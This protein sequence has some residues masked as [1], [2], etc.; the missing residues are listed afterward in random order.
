MVFLLFEGEINTLLGVDIQ[1]ISTF[2]QDSYNLFSIPLS[3]GIGIYI[4]WQ[5]LGPSSLTLLGVMLTVGPITMIVMK[6]MGSLQSRQ[7][8][9]K[10]KRM[11]QLSEILNNIKLLKLFGWEKPFIDKISQTRAQELKEQMIYNYYWSVVHVFFIIVPVLTVGLTFTVLTLT[12]DLPLTPKTAFVSLLVLNLLRHP[13][14]NLPN[15][16][17]NLVRCVVSYKRIKKYLKSEEME[18]RDQQI[19]DN[20]EDSSEFAIE[21]KDCSFSWSFRDQ[22]LLKNIDLNVKKGSLVAIVGRVGAGKS[23]IFSALLGD[24]YQKNGIEKRMSGSV[25]YVPQTA[26][27]LNTSLKKNIIFMSDYSVEKYQRVVT[28]CAL[29][30]DFDLLPA[31][32][33]TEIGEKGINL[34][35]GQKHRVSLARAVY[36]DSDLYLLDDPLSAVDAHVAQ[37]LFNEV[38]GPTG[39]LSKKTRLL[40][41]H[42]LQFLRDVDQI[43]VMSGG[44][45]IGSGSYEEL[46]SKGML[47]EQIL[48]ESDET[49]IA[50]ED[51]LQRQSSQISSNESNGRISRQIS[52]Q[53]TDSNVDKPKTIKEKLEKDAERDQLIDKEYQQMGVVGLRVY[54]NYI[55]RVGPVFIIIAFLSAFTSNSSE[56]GG[57]YF[58]NVWS[59]QNST[60]IEDPSNK[61]TFLSIYLSTVLLNAIF[62]AINQ[63]VFRMGT[64]RAAANLHKDMLFSVMRTPLSFFDTTPLGRI[65]N[66]FNHDISNIDNDLQ[67]WALETFDCMIGFIIILLIIIYQNPLLSIQVLIVVVVFAVIYV[68]PI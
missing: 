26:W 33:M 64:V 60:Q 38:I 12:S 41:T 44:R 61:R 65:V 1:Q 23:S 15:V 68:S 58:L 2:A 59:S 8:E 10:D 4:M 46:S 9:L 42:N 54:W 52:R 31:R 62:C 67:F 21:L 19:Y 55:R 51:S 36:Q 53:R 20:Y 13:L 6:R 24:M 5:Y 18:E 3:I 22:P 14:S 25:A 45:I 7:M 35:G 48:T 16:L 28:A 39:L 50:S 43:L 49:S 56:I 30:P 47:S 27:I 57:N 34:S 37:H 40:A 32:D 29:R 63:I 66:R 17:T 11:E